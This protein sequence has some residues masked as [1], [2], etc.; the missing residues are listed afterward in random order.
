M[1]GSAGG[2]GHEMPSGI[3][4]DRILA[5]F[6]TVSS[7]V[8]LEH[9]RGEPR[10][11]ARLMEI[12]ARHYGLSAVDNDIEPADRALAD[13][14]RE[15]LDAIA[16]RAGVVVN[17]RVFLREIRGPMLTA[18]G[19]RFGAQALEDARRH[20]ELAADRMPVGDIDALE[21]AVQRDGEAC[22]GAWIATLAEPL[23]RT[24]KLKWPDDMSV[25]AVPDEGL[26]EGYGDRGPQI[27]RRLILDREDAS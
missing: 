2:A 1:S 9:L 17:A 3:H 15:E 19:E 25:P 6:S 10:F 7:P 27:L 24:V 4:A 18:L 13:L 14:P 26:R 8:V 23:A 11:A 22:L 5:C 12:V 21:K 16:L 20:G